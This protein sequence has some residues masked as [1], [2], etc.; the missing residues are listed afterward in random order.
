M[1]QCHDSVISEGNTVTPSVPEPVA[2]DANDANDEELHI[3]SNEPI[4]RESA[5]DH[6]KITL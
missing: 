3:L 1:L 4:D 2:H 6:M 5:G